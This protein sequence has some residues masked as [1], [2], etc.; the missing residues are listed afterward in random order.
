MVRAF[1]RDTKGHSTPPFN[2]AARDQISAEDFATLKESVTQQKSETEGQTECT[3]CP[4]FDHARP[5]RE[6]AA[7]QHGFR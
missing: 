7:Q 2:V 3:R 5:A 4:D 1:H 6:N